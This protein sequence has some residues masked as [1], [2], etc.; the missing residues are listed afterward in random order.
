MVAPPVRYTSPD[1]DSAR[2][3]GFPFR[4]GDIVISTRSKSGTTWMQ[5][6]CAL[7]V[8][9]DPELPAPLVELSPWLDWLVQDRDNLFARLAAQGHRRFIKTHTPLDGVPIDDRATYIVVARHPL[10]AAV[11]LFHQG[12]NIDRERWRQLTG[13]PEPATPRRPRPSA[14][15]WL[16]DWIDRDD[17]PRTE[18]D[19][20][21]GVMHHLFDAWS[22]RDRPNVLLVHYDDLSNDLAGEMHRLAMR[23]GID[24]P[25]SIWPS[26]VDAATFASMRAAADDT[27][28][29]QSGVIKDRAAFFR[30]GTSGAARE[31]LTRDE[32]ARYHARVTGM[33]PRDLLS[34]LHR[35]D[36]AGD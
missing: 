22:R 28:P 19:S 15:D 13:A 6:I 7:L 17:D 12:D 27:A 8:F 18:L 36:V 35:Q 2:W 9:Q 21:P 30:R 14:R 3:E 24:V 16:L 10:D 11:S 25:A 26:L 34:W 23:L 1:E 4:V 31:L 29:D 5:M 20:L 33:A 32:L